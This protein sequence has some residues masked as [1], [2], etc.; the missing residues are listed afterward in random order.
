L[1]IQNLH[2]MIAG[3]LLAVSSLP[4][5][6]A[7]NTIEY[8]ALGDSVAF[9]YKPP[10]PGQIP[11][12]PLPGVYM[13]YPEFVAQQVPALDSLAS[14]ACPGE[15]S[16]SYL[17]SPAVSLVPDAG[18]LAFKT[19]PLLGL[20]TGY[21]GTQ[22]AETVATLVNGPNIK[23]VTLNIGGNDLVLI[24]QACLPPGPNFAACILGK[25][26]AA[27]TAYGKNL[28]RIL[29]RIRVD[30]GY[31]GKLVLMTQF[32]PDY[33]DPI[34]TGGIAALNIVMRSVAAAFNAEVAE[35]FAA[36]ALAS[37]SKGG[38]VCAAGLLVP[39][40]PGSTTT[41]DVHPT[42]KGQKILADMVLRELQ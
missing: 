40:P 36:F 15:T 18:C 29:T 22:D 37:A 27:L 19:F 2:Y 16:A 20:K 5:F 23:L 21:L 38:N 8:L 4:A 13:G 12:Q 7:S 28:T 34:Q 9:G 31:R 14:L 41:C 35:G 11:F 32:S 17:V 25:L 26:P 3:C 42:E 30:G 33:R 39:Y 24:Q 1:N 6:A 10:P